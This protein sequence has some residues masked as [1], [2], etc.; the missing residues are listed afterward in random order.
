MQTENHIF[1]CE[2]DLQ[3]LMLSVS[4]SVSQSVRGHVEMNDGNDGMTPEGNV[5]EMNASYQNE[6]KVKV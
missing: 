1:V 6:T 4:Q 3:I 2:A 5:D